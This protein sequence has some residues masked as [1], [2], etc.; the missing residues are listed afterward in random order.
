MII[1][2]LATTLDSMQTF[3]CASIFLA[4]LIFIVV[5]LEIIG[6]AYANSSVTNTSETST[7]NELRTNSSTR[8]HSDLIKTCTSFRDILSEDAAY[9][10]DYSMLYY[11]GRCEFYSDMTMNNESGNIIETQ[12][13]FSF[14]SDP[15]INE[16]IEEHSLTHAPRS[17]ALIP[18][19]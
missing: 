6:N 3:T 18:F 19:K 17:P 7:L 13:D 4:L 16:Y 10:C 8:T 5:F 15:R 12:N 11:K 14:C 9:S 2:T 1:F